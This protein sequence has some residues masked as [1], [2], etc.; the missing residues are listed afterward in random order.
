MTEV[1]RAI[2]LMSGTSM[3]GIDVALIETDGQA[4][5]NRRADWSIDYAPGQR[6]IIADA[7]AQAW[8]NMQVSLISLI[9]PEAIIHKT[10]AKSALNLI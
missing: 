4:V 9:T 8:C 7:I 2:G 5:V 6:K 3:D 1:L 10:I